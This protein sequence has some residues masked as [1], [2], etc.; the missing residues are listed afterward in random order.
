MRTLVSDALKCDELSYALDIIGTDDGKKPEEYTDAEIIAEA[1]YCLN[2]YYE[3]GTNHSEMMS[4]S[5][6]KDSLRIA[7]REVKQL[8][9]FLAKHDPPT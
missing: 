8:K 2:L 4:G 7:R 9:A 5:C 6:G 1:K 3:G